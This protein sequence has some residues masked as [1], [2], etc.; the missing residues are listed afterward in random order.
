MGVPGPSCAGTHYVALPAS[1]SSAGTEDVYHL[2]VLKKTSEC[3]HKSSDDFIFYL[4]LTHFF[5]GKP[6][7]GG[8]VPFGKGERWH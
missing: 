3:L 8:C 1:S 5:L 7:K 4:F 2:H 6:G